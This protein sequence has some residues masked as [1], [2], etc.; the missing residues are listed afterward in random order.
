MGPATPAAAW[1]RTALG[2][3]V[4]SDVERPGRRDPSGQII[5]AYI[6]K[7]ELRRLL[8]VA[9]RGAVRTDVSH[10][11]HR[12]YH[13][14]AN[15]RLPEAERLAETVTAWW[16]QI[17]AFLRLDV[18]NAG[19]ESVNRQIKTQGRLARGF[20]NLE[21]QR[22]RVRFACLPR[23]RRATVPGHMPLSVR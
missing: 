19:T 16:P 18:T 7:K 15:S 13:W 14:A 23:T 10:H 6:V 17:E 4:H 5:T 9:R 20:R 3:T 22:R 1:L 8:A 21:N 12:F 11:L 2:T